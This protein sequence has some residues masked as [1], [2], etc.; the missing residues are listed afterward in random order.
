MI[1]IK[2][3]ARS[4]LV[5]YVAPRRMMTAPFLVLGD[6][7]IGMDTFVKGEEYV[8]KATYCVRYIVHSDPTLTDQQWAEKVAFEK[9][10][11]T[12]ILAQSV[13]G[14]I[15]YRLSKILQEARYQSR[16]MDDPLVEEIQKLLEEVEGTMK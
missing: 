7:K 11:A 8:L 14:E 1:S 16:D 4:T 2:E 5:G 10:Q 12:R 6:E 15:T 13:Y 9:Q 3:A